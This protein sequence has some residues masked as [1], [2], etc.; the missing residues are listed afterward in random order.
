VT[1]RTL[2]AW[3]KVTLELKMRLE[4]EREVMTM[5]EVK[6]GLLETMKVGWLD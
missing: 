1:T 6:L 4:L 2:T 5:K 3:L